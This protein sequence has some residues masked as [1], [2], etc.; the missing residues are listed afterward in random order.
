MS[1]GGVTRRQMMKAGT[2]LLAAPVLPAVEPS[3]V[4]RAPFKLLY[5]SDTTHI[6]TC[7]SVWRPRK[8]PLQAF[9]FAKAVDES[10]EA[11]ADAFLIAPGLGWVPW[12]PSQVL[13]LEEHTAWFRR[14]F[15]LPKAATSFTS[16]VL[17]GGDFL[18]LTVDR[19][20]E[21]GAACLVSFRLNDVHH[22][23]TADHPGNSHIASVPRFYAEHPE[24]RL[25]EQP[26]ATQISWARHVHNWAIPEVRE[27]KF[28]FL[29]ELCRLYDLDG[30]ELD[31]YRAPAYFRAAETSREQRARIMSEFVARV[32]RT[33]DEHA[34]PGRRRWLGV[35]IPARIAAHDALGVD[36]AAFAA[37]GVDFFNLSASYHVEQS[38]SL[39]EIR[40]RVPGAGIYLELT[41]VVSFNGD[42]R[43]RSHRRTTPEIYTTTAHLA[44]AWGADGVS[45]FNFQYYRDYRDPGQ[46]GD[47]GPYAEPPFHLLADLRRP[48]DLGS[49]PQ[50]Y[51]T[52]SIY[53]TDPRRAYPFPRRVKG[54][55]TLVCRMDLAPPTGGWKQ[56]GRL[57]LQAREAFPA[58][59]EG[60]A[61]ACNGHPLTASAQTGEPYPTPFIQMHGRPDEWLAWNVPHAALRDGENE[62]TFSVPKDTTLELLGMD[63]ALPSSEEDPPLTPI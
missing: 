41:H 2:A 59:R 57:R 9:M 28:R 10:V 58:A 37:A 63:L 26:R 29:E 3:R 36:V 53:R 50:H 39:A 15:Q 24:F 1:E 32:R 60:W 61:A 12:W 21:K 13:P 11:G 43:H 45:L 38:T 47:D 18:K 5:N 44:H 23:E 51:F 52:G 8:E 16:F 46:V 34:R 17:N 62:I 6:L 20:H 31:F 7:T 40:R 49:R 35:R 14:H 4:I 19:C 54:G 27:F 33:L 25:G 55:E 22:K 48:G 56:P 42:T 30:V